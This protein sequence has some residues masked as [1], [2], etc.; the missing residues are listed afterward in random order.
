MN[1]KM[2]QQAKSGSFKSGFKG[3][4]GGGSKF[5]VPQDK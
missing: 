5:G 4:G 2:G 3:F 1:K